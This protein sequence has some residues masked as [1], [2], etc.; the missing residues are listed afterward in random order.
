MCAYKSAPE[1][2]FLFLLFQWYFIDPSFFF[3]VSDVL[4]IGS[5]NW[6]ERYCSVIQGRCLDSNI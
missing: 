4:Y 2:I 1:I 6:S 3:H 5:E